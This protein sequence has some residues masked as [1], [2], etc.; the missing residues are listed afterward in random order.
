ML[1]LPRWL[2]CR[3]CCSLIAAYNRRR[4]MV[5]GK[6]GTVYVKC[7]HLFPS[8]GGGVDFCNAKTITTGKCM[9]GACSVALS[10][11]RE[12][13]TCCLQTTCRGAHT[14]RA[15]RKP[16]AAG[17]FEWLEV[18]C[19]SKTTQTSNAIPVVG[20]KRGLQQ[21]CTIYVTRLGGLGRRMAGNLN[22]HICFI[23]F[24]EV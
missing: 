11:E 10:L 23:V 3:C 14:E 5:T 6:G 12:N 24:V 21:R 20:D 4:D 8:N 17:W 15:F 1:T 18:V 16:K 9:V 13:E 7:H 19:Y 2:S 22:L